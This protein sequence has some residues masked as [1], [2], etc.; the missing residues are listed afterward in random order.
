MMNDKGLFPPVRIPGTLE[1]E[2][3]IHPFRPSSKVTNACGT[4]LE[5][6]ASSNKAKTRAN[7][8]KD[9]TV[10]DAETGK[11]I[12]LTKSV[13]TGREGRLDING[14]TVLAMGTGVLDILSKDRSPGAFKEQ[15][16]NMQKNNERGET[17]KNDLVEMFH[18]RGPLKIIFHKYWD[19]KTGEINEDLR[20]EECIPPSDSE[21][22]V[23]SSDEEEYNANTGVSILHHH[24]DND[25][26]RDFRDLSIAGS[27]ARNSADISRHAQSESSSFQFRGGTS[28]STFDS[29]VG[30]SIT[31]EDSTE[32][33]PPVKMGSR[34]VSSHF[35]DAG[36]TQQLNLTNLNRAANSSCGSSRSKSPSVSSRNKQQGHQSGRGGGLTDR[37]DDSSLD[38]FRSNSSRKSVGRGSVRY[39]RL[40]ISG[41]VRTGKPS[42]LAGLSARS[43]S[44]RTRKASTKSK[45]TINSLVSR[46]VPGD[47]GDSF[48]NDDADTYSI[49]RMLPTNQQSLLDDET[50]LSPVLAKGQTWK[51]LERKYYVELYNTVTQMEKNKF[52]TQEKLYEGMIGLDSICRELA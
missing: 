50:M 42:A 39:N 51:D 11:P 49:S 27:D 6:R 3:F 47:G 26:D 35:S 10:I 4:P 24:V 28:A 38:S 20:R 32:L 17:K 21:S 52:K 2:H 44:S 33:D 46:I 8:E 36:S 25:E 5:K 19:P 1:Y 9:E 13:W 14:K 16:K 48:E 37:S 29:V 23:N 45:A 22:D 12:K 30:G 18:E 41:A 43:N 31:E 34:S 40:S 15:H 7:V